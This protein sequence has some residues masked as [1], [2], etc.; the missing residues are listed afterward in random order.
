MKKGNPMATTLVSTTKVS[1]YVHQGCPFHTQTELP[2][3]GLIS[4]ILNVVAT[5]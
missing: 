4:D 3:E 2:Q 1:A 5:Q